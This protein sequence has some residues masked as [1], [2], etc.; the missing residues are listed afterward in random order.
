[1]DEQVQQT[2][3]RRLPREVRE[4][5]ILAAAIRVFSANGYHN[6]SMD[7]ISSLAGVSKPMI[8]SYLGAKEDLFTICIR[9]EA[10]KLVASIGR[11]I[12]TEAAPDIQLWHG[13][14][15]AL[16]FIGE[17]RDSWRVLHR[18]AQSQGQPFV[19][20]IAQLREQAIGLVAGLLTAAAE[21][22][23]L[24]GDATEALQALAAAL[25]GATE[26]I[27]DWWLDHPE[28]SARK[29]ASWLMNMVWMGFGD[30]VQGSVWTPP[31]ASDTA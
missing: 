31:P 23:Q 11:E 9:R 21:H 20:E 27:A 13:L 15:G 3:N 24:D 30:L 16:R 14:L 18:Q 6:A 7:E 4:R 12:P 8:Y 2:R 25:V 26:S 10:H 19:G 17:H 29:L 1:M 5:E 28:T 22:R